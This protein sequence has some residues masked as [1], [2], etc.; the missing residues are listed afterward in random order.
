MSMSDGTA[1]IIAAAIGAAVGIPGAI[2]AGVIAYRAGRR[3]VADQS[4]VNHRH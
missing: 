3:Q 2:G 1:A 4:V